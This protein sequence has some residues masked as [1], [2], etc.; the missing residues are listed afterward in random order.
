MSADS[1]PE[2]AVLLDDVSPAVRERAWSDFLSRYSRLLLKSAGRFGGDYD[3]RMN[4]YR[5]LIEALAADDYQRL[6]GYHVS[7]HSSFPAWLTVV[8]R[9]LCVDFERARY[10]R[11]GRATAD[12]EAAREARDARRRLDKLS[13]D[14]AS[15][16]R[17]PDADR[18]AE[19][20]VHTSE[21][22]RAIGSAL[23]E[24][25]P[26]DRLLL[27]LRFRDGLAI[28][29]IATVMGFATVFHVYRRL[30]PLLQEVRRLLEARGIHDA[31]F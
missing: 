13:G 9:R 14:A 10:G 25:E 30:R 23:A 18:D 6:R 28:R 3:A 19:A 1:P 11:G 29:E 21:R 26:R 20:R 8:T 12:P 16:D 15:L 7:S 22:D 31:G 5:H 2:L 17:L 27:Q 24:L 4:R